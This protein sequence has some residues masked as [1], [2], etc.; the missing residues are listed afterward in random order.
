MKYRDYT[1]MIGKKYGRWLVK[2]IESDGIRKV[3]T[4]VCDCGTEKQVRVSTLDS[5]E[6]TSCGCYAKEQSS[7]RSRL[8]GLSRTSEYQSYSSMVHR[9]TN[10][11]DQDWH[12][13][14][15]RGI[16]VCDRWLEPDGKG[17]LN[18][19]EDMGEKPH[20]YEIDRIDVNGN[21]EPSNCRWATRKEQT[22]NTR[23]NH[24]VE[25]NGESK[26][27]A[28]WSDELNIPYKI[29]IDRLGK[30]RWSV[31]KA[32]TH[33]FKPKRMLLC[34]GGSQFEVKDV[35]KTPP[36]QFARAKGL[37]LT[38]YQFFATLFKD[39]FEVR[40]YMGGEWCDIKPLNEELGEFRL[41]LKP[42][43]EQYCRSNG[44]TIGGRL[45]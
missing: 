7:Q 24:I 42:E 2:S 37:G 21:Y 44:L 19:L 40:A 31:E 33:P 8:H 36:N 1:P 13:Y 39:E 22:R 41:N 4:C 28:E 9:C 25:Y 11:T 35:F 6:S 5:G 16:K 17:F 15:G 29:L 23:F 26:C 32:F 30:L 45:V 12:H 20:K 38:F 34:R 10:S 14:G 43:F 18:F 27:L 3:A